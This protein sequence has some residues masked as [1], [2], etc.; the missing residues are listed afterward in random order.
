[1]VDI[2][3]T[4]KMPPVPESMFTFIEHPSFNPFFTSKS[5]FSCYRRAWYFDLSHFYF[6]FR[7]GLVVLV[8]S[9][10]R[11]TSSNYF[12]FHSRIAKNWHLSK[13][14]ETYHNIDIP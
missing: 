3:C 8:S 7:D 2:R 10:G 4:S 12:T 5:S 6:S 11:S 9:N 14:A 1:M 13:I